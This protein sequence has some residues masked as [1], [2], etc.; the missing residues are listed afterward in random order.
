[1]LEVS[2]GLFADYK[3]P[4]P[5]QKRT[6]SFW[7]AQAEEC[8]KD[9]K[10]PKQQESLIYKHFHADLQKATTVWRRMKEMPPKRTPALYFA[11]CMKIK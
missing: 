3:P 9:L 8:I 10:I 5:S 7:Q 1:M 6:H 4:K 11:K 2:K